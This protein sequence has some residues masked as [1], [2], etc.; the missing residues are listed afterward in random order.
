MAIGAFIPLALFVVI[1]GSVGCRLI[2]LWRRTR[3]VPE[4]LLGFGLPIVGASFPLTAV[5][6]APATALEPVGR[7]CFAGGLGISVVGLALIIFFSYWVFRRGSPFAL[8]FFALVCAALAGSVAYISAVNF[9]GDDIAQIKRAM[10]PGTLTMMCATMA[11][12]AWSG[13]ESLRYRAASRRQLALG[14]ADPVVVNRFLLWGLAGLTGSALM[15]VIVV[16]I[17][18]DM[19]IMREPLPLAVIACSG[20]VASATWYLTFLAPPRY[21][22][23][24]RARAAQNS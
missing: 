23:F 18:A 11:A 2:G 6:R 12:F 13:V 8:A 10:R 19:T 14:L 9:A 1:L 17:L 5:G 4:M 22:A 20:M 24:V 16:C 15:G 21:L 7:W 3:Q